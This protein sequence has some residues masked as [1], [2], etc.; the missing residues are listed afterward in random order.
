M[1]RKTTAKTA[2]DTRDEIPRRS[3]HRTGTEQAEPRKPANTF[4][5]PIF[6]PDLL[7]Q[8]PAAKSGFLF[9]DYGFGKDPRISQFQVIQIWH[10]FLQK[11]KGYKGLMVKEDAAPDEILQLLRDKTNQ[12]F[13]GYQ[14]LLNIKKDEY[15]PEDA[16]WYYKDQ[17]QADWNMCSIDW[18]YFHKDANVRGAGLEV[19]KRIAKA[20]KVDV[21]ENY[22]TEYE[23]AEWRTSEELHTWLVDNVGYN[24]YHEDGKTEDAAYTKIYNL[25]WSYKH[26][27]VAK[28]K[29]AFDNVDMKFPVREGVMKIKNAKLRKWF[30][31]GLDLLENPVHIT[32]FA[33]GRHINGEDERPVSITETVFFP[34]TFKDAIYESAENILDEMAGNEG[35]ESYYEWGEIREARHEKPAPIAELKKLFAF[36]NKGHEI[37]LNDYHDKIEYN[38]H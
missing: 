19:I 26:G 29:K 32:R 18:I 12:L 3:D 8:T 16:L 24:R 17:G 15:D 11:Q 7:K 37:Y 20:Y 22:N 28:L 30:L 9:S 14:W 4:T 1:A 13:P 33:F 6:R 25:Y 36:I 2:T 27:E 34:F 35:V 23:L 38:G 31:S 5:R 10:K 21:I